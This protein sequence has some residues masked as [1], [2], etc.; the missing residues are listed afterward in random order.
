MLSGSLPT[1]NAITARTCER[2][3]LLGH[4]LLGDLGL[5]HRQR[6]EAGLAEER[7]HEGAMTGD[8]PEG[9]PF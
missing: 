9:R 6:Q 8:H 3:P 2:D 4:A 5:A 7:Q 1:L